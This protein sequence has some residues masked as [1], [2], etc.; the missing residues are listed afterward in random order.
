MV[1]KIAVLAMPGKRSPDDRGQYAAEFNSLV[2]DADYERHFHDKGIRQGCRNLDIEYEDQCVSLRIGN[3]Y[4]LTAQDLGCGA[5]FR[6]LCRWRHH[7]V[8]ND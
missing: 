7:E 4:L 3:G 6:E 1:V 8:R 5:P 2:V